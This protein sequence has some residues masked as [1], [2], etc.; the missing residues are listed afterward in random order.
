MMSPS[1]QIRAYRCRLIFSILI[2]TCC[3]YAFP[4]FTSAALAAQDTERWP[5]LAAIIQ[6]QVKQLDAVGVDA[7]EVEAFIR[8]AAANGA[9]LVVTPETPFYRYSIW[10]RH[11]VTQLDLANS[12]DS[13]VSRF[14]SLSREL[15]ICLVIGLRKPSGNSHLPVYNVALFF[16][17]NG[18][19]LGMH[20]KVI[21][22]V[23]ET[24]FTKSGN[25]GDL[26]VFMTPYGKTG[27]L[28]CKDMDEYWPS[29]A[30]ISQGMDLL[31]G[32]SA[33]AS[34][35][36]APGRGW[37]NV[38]PACAIGGVCYGIAANQIG[39]N[40]I[41]TTGGGSGF[42]APGGHRLSAAGYDGIPNDERILYQTLLLPDANHSVNL[43]APLFLLLH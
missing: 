28:I 41:D 37:Q 11:G 24:S 12:Y 23:T 31:I 26:Q 5:V 34:I 17:P 33:A 6:Y 13:L 1:F 20:H 40:S 7:D 9:K 36:G 14:S 25:Q 18:D 21:I 4:A 15:G 8:E 39:T 42:V 3:L 32:I 2:T 30:L 10:L 22:S 38:Y 27:M 19:I 16:G 43:S 35:G 29:K